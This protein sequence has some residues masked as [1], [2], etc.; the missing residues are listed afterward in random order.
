MANA[1]TNTAT[2]TTTVSSQRLQGKPLFRLRRGAGRR[3]R[4]AAF[5]RPEDCRLAGFLGAAFFGG[6]PRLVANLR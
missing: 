4:G 6:F 2:P 1:E 5:R 3:F